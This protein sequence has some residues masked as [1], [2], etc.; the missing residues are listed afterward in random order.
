MHL[1][2]ILLKKQ[3]IKKKKITITSRNKQ[4]RKKTIKTNPINQVFA[5]SNTLYSFLYNTFLLPFFVLLGW[6][7][8]SGNFSHIIKTGLQNMSYH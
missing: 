5:K 8:K 2:L 7:I 6:G 4:K 1:V 3:Q